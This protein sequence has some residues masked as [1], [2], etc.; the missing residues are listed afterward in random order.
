M[1]AGEPPDL[2]SH[3]RDRWVDST[4]AHFRILHLLDRVTAGLVRRYP[5]E[6]QLSGTIVQNGVET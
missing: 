4:I 5:L 1:N 3:G 6:A 2:F